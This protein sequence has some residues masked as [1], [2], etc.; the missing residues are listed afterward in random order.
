M[1]S[2][3]QCSDVAEIGNLF[4]DR[5]LKTLQ[6]LSELAAGIVAPGP[7]RAVTRKRE[8]EIL[9]CG[10]VRHNWQPGNLDRI[11][12]RLKVHDAAIR[13]QLSVRIE[14]PRPNCTVLFKGETELRTSGNARDIS[15]TCDLH[16]SRGVNVGT[17]SKLA[18]RVEAEGPDRLIRL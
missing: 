1:V 18:H 13:S 2:T 16:W 4:G 8:T 6:A 15:K 14:A 12:M 7:Y 11:R 10:K 9:P 3:C 5:V 17:V